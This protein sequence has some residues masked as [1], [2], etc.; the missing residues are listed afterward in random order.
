MGRKMSGLK[1]YTELPY[2]LHMLTTRRITLLNPKSWVDRNDSFFIRRYQ[3]RRKLKSVLV[4]CLTKSAATYHQWHVFAAN[5]S[6]VRIEFHEE[7]FRQWSAAIEN[8]RLEPVRYLKLDKELLAQLTLDELPFAKRHAF[9]HEGEI[10]LIVEESKKELPFLD[11]PFDYGM[12]KEI[13]V[14]PWL[15][16]AVFPS[17]KAAIRGAAPAAEFH[18]RATT[19]LE[20]KLFMSAA[21]NEA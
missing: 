2:L 14:S 17:V 7:I 16:Q 8:S 18:I 3:E 10:R 1:R 20:S 13:I 21:E 19:M 9:R 6:G 4:M 11:I 5:A 12:V 15:P